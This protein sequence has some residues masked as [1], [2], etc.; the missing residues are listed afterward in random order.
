MTVQPNSIEGRDIAFHLHSYTNARKHEANGPFKGGESI[1]WGD[2]GA[3]SG[4]ASTAMAPSEGST[5]ASGEKRA[6]GLSP[7]ATLNKRFA[8]LTKSSDDNRVAAMDEQ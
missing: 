2:R 6:G 4:V 1:A 3:W 7:D 5:S 8:A